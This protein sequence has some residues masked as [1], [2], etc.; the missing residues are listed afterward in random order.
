[1]KFVP[2]LILD[3][4]LNKIAGSSTMVCVCAGSPITYAH[5]VAPVTTTGCNLAMLPIAATG[6]FT[7]PADGS[8]NGRTLTVTA[9]TG[10]SIV[11]SGSALA[12]ALINMAAGSVVYITTCT[13]QYLVAGGTVDI[14]SW[15]I[16]LADPT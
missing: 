15:T 9:R 3:S 6:C 13:E 16:N 11:Y 12:V 4:Y 10:A 14:P 8:P 1:M 5:C 2:D 7:G